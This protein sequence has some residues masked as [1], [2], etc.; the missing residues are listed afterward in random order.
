VPPLPLAMAILMF[1]RTLLVTLFLSRG[2]ADYHVEV[3]PACRGECAFV[4]P[5]ERLGHGPIGNLVYGHSGSLQGAERLGTAVTGYER[6]GVG[7][8]DLLGGL[9]A[10]I[11]GSVHPRLIVNGLYRPVG[12]VDDEQVA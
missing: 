11:R 4:E 1:P 7:V 6:I 2:P 12:H 8:Y 9:D 3:R 5:V 10:G